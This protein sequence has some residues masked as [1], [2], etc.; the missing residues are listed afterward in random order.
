MHSGQKF[1]LF[2]AKRYKDIFIF[3]KNKD[4]FPLKK[5]RQHLLTSYFAMV[6]ATGIVAIA[7]H[8][9]G[10][11]AVAFVIHLL[12]LVLYGVLLLLFLL[13]ICFFWFEI[14]KD[15]KDYQKGPGFFTFVAGTAIVGNQLV[16]I[17]S[18]PQLASLLLK[19]AIAAW[20]LITYSFFVIIT[21][22]EEKPTLDKGINGSWLII[23][24]ST[25]AVST[26]ITS[27]TSY[28]RHPEIDAFSALVF[29]MAGGI[30]YLYIMSLIIYRLS[31]FQLKADELGAPYWINMG[32]AAITTLAG[33]K[34]ISGMNETGELVEFIPFLKGFT[35]FFWSASTWW[36]P[37]MLI[38][39]TWRH[40]YKRIPL[41]VSPQGY[42]AGYWGMVFPLGMYTVCTVQ[43]SDALELPF[44]KVIP[45]FFIFVALFAWAAV[46]T[47]FVRHQFK[48]L[49]FTRS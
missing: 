40:V 6:M 36:I 14:V 11:T 23:I 18:F 45:R 34:L 37:L 20:V 33:S 42:N 39:G 3:V 47:G 21:V 7:A 25:Q 29:Y 24:V 49:Q 1:D 22:K 15:M 38:L 32:A 41:P 2:C 35:L 9:L 17:E 48:K 19:I 44:L 26:L 10:Y 43:L 16:I 31:F 12:N 46:M 30:M 8:L 4:R 5:E 13:R 27:L 28:S